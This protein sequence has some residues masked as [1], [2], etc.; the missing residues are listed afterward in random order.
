MCR[1]NDD[2]AMA[3][4]PIGNRAVALERGEIVAWAVAVGENYNGEIISIDGSCDLEVEI[5]SAV[6]GGESDWC[7]GENG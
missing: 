1:L 7:E 2:K 6:F 4:P 5:D 3:S